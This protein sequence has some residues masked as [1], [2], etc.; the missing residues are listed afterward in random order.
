MK[1]RC[2]RLGKLCPSPVPPWAQEEDL[3]ES[4]VDQGRGAKAR[5]TAT[6]QG[7]V[8]TASRGVRWGA[9]RLHGQGG[10]RVQ[11][12]VLWDSAAMQR[13]GLGTARAPRA[14]RSCSQTARGGL[15]PGGG[16]PPRTG[17][18]GGFVSA[19]RG[20]LGSD[21][22]GRVAETRPATSPGPRGL[23]R[24]ADARR[25]P[26]DTWTG[27]SRGP[28]A[29]AHADA[30]LAHSHMSLAHRAMLTSHYL[31]YC[32]YIIRCFMQNYPPRTN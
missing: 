6:R 4:S 3:R 29:S 2:A 31:C 27:V 9:A 1:P 24:G 25:H 32:N 16:S 21:P 28:G 11:A 13:R 23:R 22:R 30:D 26:R 5:K 15:S 19:L 18:G 7:G 20:K 8:P 10:G 14:P 12:P 17:G